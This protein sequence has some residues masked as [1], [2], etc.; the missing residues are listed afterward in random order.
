MCGVSSSESN[1]CRVSVCWSITPYAS[2]LSPERFH[3]PIYIYIY[4]YNSERYN[5]QVYVI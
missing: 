2:F 5:V 4:Q 1:F 3:K